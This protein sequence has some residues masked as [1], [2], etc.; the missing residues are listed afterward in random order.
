MSWCF[1]RLEDSGSSDHRNAVSLRGQPKEIAMG[2]D[3]QPRSAERQK[4]QENLSLETRQTIALER[5]ADAFDDL[6][7]EF[8][9]MGTALTRIA[10]RVGRRDD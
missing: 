9:N 10:N 6:R 3:D 2:D 7:N 1:A 5:I 4:L 8:R